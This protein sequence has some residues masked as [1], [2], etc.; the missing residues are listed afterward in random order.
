V[1]VVRRVEAPVDEIDLGTT[2]GVLRVD[3]AAHGVSH[4]SLC[5]VDAEA[6]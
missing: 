6:R 2:A 1:H 5:G 4:E 3:T